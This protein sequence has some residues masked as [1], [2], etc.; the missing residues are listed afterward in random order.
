M[1]KYFDNLVDS[2]RL[3]IPIIKMLDFEVDFK[4]KQTVIHSVTTAYIVKSIGEK[5]GLEKDLFE[6]LFLEECY[7]W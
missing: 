3:L 7:I 5:L 4:S 1:E 6:D 2:S